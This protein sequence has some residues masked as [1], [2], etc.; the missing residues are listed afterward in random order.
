MT[1]EN[2]GG[3]SGKATSDDLKRRSL[4]LSM[5]L[6]NARIEESIVPERREE[7]IKRFTDALHTPSSEHTAKAPHQGEIPK[8]G[9]GFLQEP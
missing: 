6:E 7:H 3:A 4:E 5:H 2:Q 1:N 8:K 9:S